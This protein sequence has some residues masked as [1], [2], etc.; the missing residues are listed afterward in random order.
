MTLFILYA[1]LQAYTLDWN[2]VDGIKVSTSILLIRL[3]IR[4]PTLGHDGK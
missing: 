4:H 3:L 2:L 1:L